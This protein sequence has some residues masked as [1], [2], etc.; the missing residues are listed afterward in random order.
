MIRFKLQYCVQTLGGSAMRKLIL[1][2]LAVGLM[3]CPEHEAQVL[4]AQANLKP[5]DSCIAQPQVGSQAETI[6][7]GRLDLA[8]NREGYIANIQLLNFLT[9]SQQVSGLG[10]AEAHLD[11]G[12]IQVMGA[13]VRYEV[14]GLEVKLPQNFFQHA[15]TAAF[16]AEASVVQINIMPPQVVQ[17]LRTDPWL[18]GKKKFSDGLIESCYLTAAAGG[19]PSWT[20]VPVGGREVEILVIITFEGALQDGVIV[21][22]NEIRYPLRVC[23]GCLLFPQ[24]DP[25]LYLQG[26][27]FGNAS[28]FK[29]PNAPCVDGQDTCSDF[30]TCFDRNFF[31]DTAAD[32]RLASCAED[33]DYKPNQSLWQHPTNWPFVGS[34]NPAGSVSDKLN[35]LRFRYAFERVDAYCNLMDE[36]P[37]WPPAE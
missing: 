27:V 11:N 22:S 23:N 21:H 12:V 31:V 32:A 33:V 15:P 6:Q 16:P 25:G 26:T 10:P 4:F 20:N 9:T 8:S 3:G 5:D 14:E 19:N 35:H 24:M 36:A 30:G 7:V 18:S 2:L 1:A 37:L 34:Y 29:C 13:T 28:E 17:L